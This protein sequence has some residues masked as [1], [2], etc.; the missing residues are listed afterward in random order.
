MYFFDKIRAKRTET[1]LEAHLF[2][3]FSFKNTIIDKIC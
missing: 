1:H 2:Q 3:N